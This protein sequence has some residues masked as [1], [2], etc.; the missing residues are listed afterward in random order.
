MQRHEYPEAPGLKAF[1]QDERAMDAHHDHHPPAGFN[2]GFARK[3]ALL[4]CWRYPPLAQG[5]LR[6]FEHQKLLFFSAPPRRGGSGFNQQRNSAPLARATSV[7][8]RG[9]VVVVVGVH[10]LVVLCRGLG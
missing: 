10:S 6:A 9:G 5:L 3:G 2:A 4:L 1:A 7:E 8:T